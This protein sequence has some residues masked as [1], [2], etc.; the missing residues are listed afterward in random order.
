MIMIYQQCRVVYQVPPVMLGRYDWTISVFSDGEEIRI[1]P[2]W[3]LPGGRWMMPADL[4]SNIPPAAL[5]ALLE[6]DKLL[7][8]ADAVKASRSNS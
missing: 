7:A 8:L 3:R 2:Q 4:K 1:I 6:P 5:T